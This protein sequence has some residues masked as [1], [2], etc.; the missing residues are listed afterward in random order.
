MAELEVFKRAQPAVDS[1]KFKK[2]QRSKFFGAPS[3]NKFRVPQE[4]RDARLT[5]IAYLV[6]KN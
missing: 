3:R 4:S 6:I 1:A 5:K 2:A